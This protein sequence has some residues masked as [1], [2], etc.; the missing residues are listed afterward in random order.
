MNRI[1]LK[2]ALRQKTKCA[3]QHDGWTCATCFFAMS[4]ELT[5]QDWQALL[6]EVVLSGEDE[7]KTLSLAYGNAALV[8]VIELAKRIIKLEAEVKALKGK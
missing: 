6:P 3:I 7:A 1:K 5:N 4:E 8:S 2:K